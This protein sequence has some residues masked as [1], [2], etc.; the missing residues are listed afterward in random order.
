M[1]CVPP[2]A[3]AVTRP[4]GLTAAP[5]ALGAMHDLRMIEGRIEAEQAELEAAASVLRAVART[6]VAAGPRQDGHDLTAET[7]GDIHGRPGHLD[8][9]LLGLA[10]CFHNDG[11]FA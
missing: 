8:R 5:P 1:T 9:D 4:A 11:R 2:G 3:S 7:N 10:S 6:L